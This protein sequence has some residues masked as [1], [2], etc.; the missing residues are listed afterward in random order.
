MVGASYYGRRGTALSDVDQTTDPHRSTP[1]D[2]KPRVLT[3]PMLDKY[4]A[5][6]VRVNVG[7]HVKLVS[8][9]HHMPL[10]G[11]GAISIHK[12]QGQ[13][14]KKAVLFLSSCNQRRQG[15]AY[16][17]LSRCVSEEGLFL[18]ERPHDGAMSA[19]HTALLFEKNISP[20]GACHYG[21]HQRCPI[22]LRF[23]LPLWHGYKHRH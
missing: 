1:D 2:E 17:A 13:S 21:A 3:V 6:P 5:S 11:A 23:F 15:A 22:C 14:F 18:G 7:D 8:Q 12:C 16:T 19:F 10:V 4:T 20:G 9:Y